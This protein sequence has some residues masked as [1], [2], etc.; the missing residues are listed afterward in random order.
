[1]LWKVN[2]TTFTVGERNYWR[3]L[4]QQNESSKWQRFIKI[5]LKQDIFAYARKVVG[6]SGS[7]SYEAF[8]EKQV[9]DAN[10]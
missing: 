2:G 9:T 1:M 8:K 6:S 10:D 5:G 7:H 4:C 3:E